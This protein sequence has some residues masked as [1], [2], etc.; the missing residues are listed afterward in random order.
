MDKLKEFEQIRIQRA[1]KAKLFLGLGFGFLGLAI[2]LLT[3][4]FLLALEIEYTYILL[5]FA[6]AVLIGAGGI[7]LLIV[8]AIYCAKWSNF[9]KNEVVKQLM[10]NEYPNCTYSPSK[11]IDKEIFF[12]PAFFRRPDIYNSSN[13]LYAFYENVKIES[14][15]YLLQDRSRDSKGHV[16]YNTYAKG[17]FLRLSFCRSFKNTVKVTEKSGLFNF[18]FSTQYKKVELESVDFNKKFLTLSTD[19]QAAFFILTPQIQEEMLRLEKCFSGGIYFCFIENH[20]FIAINNNASSYSSNI[21]RPLSGDSL[22][23]IIDEI[24]IPKRFIDAFKLN[25]EKYNMPNGNITI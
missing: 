16:H 23:K 7:V 6:L 10:I 12:E 13:Y 9:F 22:K 8:A 2:I 15:D 3:L 18:N 25:R 14:A 1:K 19:D 24:N 17:R 5:M 21:F 20:L 4:S 11:G